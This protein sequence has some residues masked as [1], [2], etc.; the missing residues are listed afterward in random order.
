MTHG[1][2]GYQDRRSSFVIR[3]CGE[4]AANHA[5]PALR[6]LPPL[7]STSHP[8]V[9]A[10]D[11]L[12]TTSIARASDGHRCSGR[13]YIALMLDL[14]RSC[15]NS[16][17]ARFTI[18]C[19]SAVARRALFSA[20]GIADIPAGVRART[21]YARG[22]DHAGANPGTFEM[23]K[24]A[25]F[26]TPGDAS[27]DR[28]PEFQR[29]ASAGAGSHPRRRRARR[30]I[31]IGLATIGNVNLDLMFAL[32]PAAPGR[33]A[34]DGGV[35]NRRASA[36]TFGA[37]HLSFYQ[38]TLEPNIAGVREETAAAAGPRSGG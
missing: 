37:P 22:R 32:P 27:V 9:R 8:V 24:F 18:R 1:Y 23:E 2:C 31:E 6:P 35:R 36:L 3:P 12:I 29:C 19:S 30:A 5:R 7:S 15:P 21:A 38:L 13:E 28:H 26:V 11:A 17:A 20:H 33:G 4:H 25:G 34:D 14:E 16:G 10:Q